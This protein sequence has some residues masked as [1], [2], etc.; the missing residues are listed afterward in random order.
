MVFEDGLGQRVP[1]ADADRYVLRVRVAL[2]AVTSF[3]FAVGERLERLAAFRH[4]NVARAAT[5]RRDADAELLVQVE[6]PT[7][8][9][10][11]ELLCGAQ[12]RQVPVG[13]TAALCGVR[14]L[15]P[16]VAALQELGTDVAHGAVTPERLIVTPDARVILTDHVFGSALDLLRYSRERYWSELRIPVPQPAANRIDQRADVLQIGLVALALIIGRPVRLEEF[17]TRIPDLL[18][19][20]VAISPDGGYE[21]LPAGVRGWLARA[22]QIGPEPPFGTAAEARE[23]LDRVLGTGELLAQP[24]ALAAFLRRYEASDPVRTDVPASDLPGVRGAM[25]GAHALPLQLGAGRTSS[26]APGGDGLLAIAAPVAA[27]RAVTPGRVRS[28]SARR[29][30]PAQPLREARVADAPWTPPAGQAVEHRRWWWNWRLA[31]A[32]VLLAG[33]VGASGSLGA[34][35][36]LLQLVDTARGTLEL[37]SIPAGA[38]VIVDG[39]PQGTTPVVL[40]LAAGSHDIQLRA[41]KLRRN[42]GL[43]I[44]K[45]E[46]VRQQVKLAK[47]TSRAARPVAARTT[48]PRDTATAV[49]TTGEAR[50]SS[51][52]PRPSGTDTPPTGEPGGM[53]H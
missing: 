46:T 15:V 45:G 16:A 33:I 18:A 12:A 1:T 30:P 38:E 8:Y 4:P 11:S 43:I 47:P 41:G 26:A 5:V 35:R 34:A 14:Q 36:Q 21:P 51:V 32:F 2:S 37:T 27:H 7:G 25:P 17:P 6:A 39:Q 3:D 13:I 22:L 24:Q 28:H 10:L 20:T 29:T 53:T 9:R 42:L 23:V 31:S 40:S 50:A 48:L 49:P 52:D 44:A 19:S